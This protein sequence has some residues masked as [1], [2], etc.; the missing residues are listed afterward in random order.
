MTQLVQK[1]C[2]E[3]AAIGSTRVGKSNRKRSDV[4]ARRYARLGLVNQAMMDGV[5]S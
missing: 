5:Q 4:Y 1:Y 3:V 2:V